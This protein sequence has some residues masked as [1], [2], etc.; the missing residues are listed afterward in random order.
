MGSQLPVKQDLIEIIT[1]VFFAL[2]DKLY[3]KDVFLINAIDHLV[4]RLLMEKP[5]TSKE[6]EFWGK[7]GTTWNFTDSE[8][9]KGMFNDIDTSE[10][11]S[12]EWRQYFCIKTLI[13]KKI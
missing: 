11:L 13:K 7:M 3:D 10:I 6:K 12:G 2:A 1:K 5:D 9:I 4:I 8:R